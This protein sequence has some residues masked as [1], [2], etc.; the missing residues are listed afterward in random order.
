MFQ[1]INGKLSVVAK[2]IRSHLP[3]ERKA[4]KRDTES[5]K[6]EIKSLKFMF[7]KN[8]PSKIFSFAFEI[9][10]GGIHLKKG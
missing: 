5:I 3:A 8:N 6:N 7:F 10:G 2:R 4:L 9:R 1:N